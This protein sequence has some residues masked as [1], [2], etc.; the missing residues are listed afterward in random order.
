MTDD[1]KIR[2]SNDRQKWQVSHEQLAEAVRKVV[3]MSAAVA[4]DLEKEV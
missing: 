4:K 2:G 1:P 3:P